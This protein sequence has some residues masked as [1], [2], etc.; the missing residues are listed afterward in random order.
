MLVSSSEGLEREGLLAAILLRALMMLVVV[1]KELAVLKIWGLR[2]VL[3]WV[4]FTGLCAKTC[5]RGT[6][7]KS[8][9]VYSLGEFHFVYRT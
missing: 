1:R 5:K 9:R 7:S 3:E 4:E 2:K 8:A 6:S